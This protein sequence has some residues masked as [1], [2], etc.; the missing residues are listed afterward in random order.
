ME[1]T[2]KYRGVAPVDELKG[3]IIEFKI[4]VLRRGRQTDG[5]FDLTGIG[6]A[7]NLER[8]NN[9]NGHKRHK[10]RRVLMCGCF[11]ALINL[12]ALQSW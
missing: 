12:P 2:S 4:S 7:R 9:V 1:N 10:S 11:P 8:A 5:C 6:Q 3:T